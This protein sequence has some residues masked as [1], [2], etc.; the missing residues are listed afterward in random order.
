MSTQHS[1][2]CEC[3]D[4][5]GTAVCNGCEVRMGRTLLDDDG[6]C[7]EHPP[8]DAPWID[9]RLSPIPGDVV[10][11]VADANNPP[12]L[13]RVTALAQRLGERTWIAELTATLKTGSF[14][15]GPADVR[16]CM[17][18]S[19]D[20]VDRLLVAMLFIAFADHE[21]RERH[22]YR[23]LATLKLWSLASALDSHDPGDEDEE[24]AAA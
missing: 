9:A 20:W 22:H 18:E 3:S 14:D 4:C 13:Y 17:V 6:F 11:H 1:R 12:R 7:A 10:R 24:G 8:L 5:D 21:I 2:G 19:T 23:Q 16:L 15:G